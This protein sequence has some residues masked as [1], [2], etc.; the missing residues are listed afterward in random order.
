MYLLLIKGCTNED[1]QE[2]Q[3]T[4]HRAGPGLSIT[5]YTQ[6]C[7]RQDRC[8]DLSTRIHFGAPR[9]TP[10]AEG[11]GRGKG[12]GGDGS[13]KA[14]GAEMSTEGLFIEIPLPLPPPSLP[15]VSRTGPPTTS[16]GSIF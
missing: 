15:T 4:Q 2:V 5:S 7:R 13:N 3:V 16:Q 12:C 6:V 8:N 1:D 11:G 14:K 9:P 10:G